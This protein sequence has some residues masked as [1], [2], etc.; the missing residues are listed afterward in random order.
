[1]TLYRSSPSAINTRCG[2]SVLAWSK[3]A[4]ENCWARTKTRPRDH[5]CCYAKF[6]FDFRRVMN[7]FLFPRH[8]RTIDLRDASCRC[9]S[10]SKEARRS[11][12]ILMNMKGGFVGS[13]QGIMRRLTCIRSRQETLHLP[14][15]RP[16]LFLRFT[17]FDMLRSAR[18]AR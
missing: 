14:P 4:W 7:G 10:W 5:R 6:L 12:T 15:L 17:H 1:M 11:G 2:V 13:G 9:I 3:R 18:D 8:S 16:F